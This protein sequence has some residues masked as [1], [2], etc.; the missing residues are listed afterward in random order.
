MPEQEVE[1]MLDELGNEV[2]TYLTQTLNSLRNEVKQARPQEGEENYEMKMAAYLELVNYITNVIKTLTNVLT[3]SFTEFRQL[4]D[5]LWK[6]IQQSQNENQVQ[7]QHVQEFLRK[8]EQTFQ[9]A[10][11]KHIEPLFA[12][13]ETGMKIPDNSPE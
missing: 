13:I 12:V 8:T 10:V 6:D 5:Q 4:I 7:Q 11:S 2:L 9:D 3:S 1:Q